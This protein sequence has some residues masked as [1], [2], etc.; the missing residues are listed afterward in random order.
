MKWPGLIFH[1][2]ARKNLSTSLQTVYVCD[3]RIIRF[4]FQKEKYNGERNEDDMLHFILSRL[5]V[6][7]MKVDKEIWERDWG[8]SSWLL[9]LCWAE[10]S[11][12]LDADTRLKLAAVLVI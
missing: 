6:T 2:K 12:C 7:V 5:K 11:A 3:K 1:V 8:S 9:V 10:D 4:L